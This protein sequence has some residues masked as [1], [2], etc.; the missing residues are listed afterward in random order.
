MSFFNYTEFGNRS[1]SY[2]LPA[3]D[4]PTELSDGLAPWIKGFVGLDHE[5]AQER[6]RKRWKLIG[7]TGLRDL[8][9]ILENFEVNAIVD[10]EVG[11]VIAATRPGVDGGRIGDTWYLPAPLERDFWQGKLKAFGLDDHQVVLE[12]F[13]HFGGLAENTFE[14]GSFRYC[15]E[16][17]SIFC[18]ECEVFPGWHWPESVRGFPDRHHS[19][20]FYQALNGSSLLLRSDGA[21]AWWIMQEQR[22]EQVAASF[23]QFLPIYAEHWTKRW[24]F[25]PYGGP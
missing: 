2:P 24:P 7:R 19:L 4:I 12:F 23:E 13:E 5:S 6:L 21:V 8:A 22:V 10:F 17:W 16:E 9:K 1:T 14:A 18:P 11:G 20:L 15:E 25:D 3:T